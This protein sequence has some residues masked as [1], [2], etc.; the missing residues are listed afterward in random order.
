MHFLKLYLSEEPH[1]S[2]PVEGITRHT[3]TNK[4]MPHVHLQTM[5]TCKT[6]EAWNG[7]SLVK[8][9]KDLQE[10]KLSLRAAAGEVGIPRS[11]LHGYAIG[12]VQSRDYI[13]S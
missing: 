7:D 10:S 13:R 9:L 1:I 5:A 6:K 8:A 4:C 3:I 2:L 12:K 11:V